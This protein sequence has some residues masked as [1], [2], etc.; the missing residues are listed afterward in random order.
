MRYAQGGGLRPHEQVARERIRLLAAD[1][2]ERGESN[3][4]IAKDL[5]VSLRS[6]ER[7]RHSWRDSGRDG[8][9]C[10]GPA[11]A[12]KVSEEEFAT[13]EEELLKGAV[14]HGWPDERW[15]LSRIQLLLARVTGVQLSVRGVWE[16]LRCHGWSCR[17]PA[18]RAVERNDAAVAGWIKDVAVGKATAAALGAWLVFEDEAA[19]S[20]TSHRSRTWAPRGPTPTVRFNGGS[21]GRIT[22]AALACYKTGERSRLIYRPRVQGHLRGDH[23]GF[24]WQDYRD[25]IVR[26]HLQ[27]GGPIVVIWDNLN[28]HRSAALRHWAAGQDWLTIIQLPTYAPD[29]N[30]VEGIWSLLR[31]STTANVV[32]ADRDHLVRAVRSGMRHIQR[33]PRLIDGCLT[34]TGLPPPP[35]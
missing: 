1:A 7:W 22:L 16:L 26:A 15:T 28:V 30:P 17:Q 6:V 2:F 18:R 34:G 31:R 32:F 33:R 27:L 12:R 35:H 14:F 5:R 29:L 24:T 13:L 8:L 21:R 9:L 11:K 20:M 25:L 10:S 3:T 19:V 23:R 4:A